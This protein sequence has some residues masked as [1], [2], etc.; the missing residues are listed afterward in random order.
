MD[1]STKIDSGTM[2]QISQALIS[3]KNIYH[4]PN[5]IL[6]IWYIFFTE[7]SACVKYLKKKKK[8]N[9]GQHVKISQIHNDFATTFKVQ[10]QINLEI[11][12]QTAPYI[13]GG[14]KID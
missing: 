10:D 11:N 2:G 14:S 1:C 7:T 13:A 4:I 3:V 12:C 9:M 8:K 5:I 6:G